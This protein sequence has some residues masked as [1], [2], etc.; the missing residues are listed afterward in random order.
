MDTYDIKSTFTLGDNHQ[1][2][3]E[4]SCPWWDLNLQPEVS[5]SLALSNELHR[6]NGRQV[7]LP[8]HLE[9]EI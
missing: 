1:K 4:Q 8:L 6:L 2:R 5:D 3:H 9:N 7:I